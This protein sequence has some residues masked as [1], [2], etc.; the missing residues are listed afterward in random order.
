MYWCQTTTPSSAQY[1]TSSGNPIAS[2]TLVGTNFEQNVTEL[3]VPSA[4]NMIGNTPQSTSVEAGVDGTERNE[5]EQNVRLTNGKTP[6]DIPDAENDS[7]FEAQIRAAA[8][9]ETDPDTKKNLWNE[10]RRYKGLPEQK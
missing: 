1:D 2:S 3:A 9:A 4:S 5:A 10:Y 6:D 8:M 7:V